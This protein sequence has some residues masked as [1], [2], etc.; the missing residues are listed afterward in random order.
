M[1][2]LDFGAVYLSR[3]L[4]EEVGAFAEQ[5]WRVGFWE[6]EGA[7]EPEGAGEDCH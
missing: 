1:V 4:G 2:M 3:K 7:E 6:E 5:D